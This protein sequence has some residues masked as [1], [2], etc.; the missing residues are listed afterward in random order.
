VR[1]LWE[2]LEPLALVLICFVVVFGVLY[3][4]VTL[5]LTVQS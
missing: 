1:S 2:L 5:F 4:A 3:G